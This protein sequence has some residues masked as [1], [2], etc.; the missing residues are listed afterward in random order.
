ML[1]RSQNESFLRNIEILGKIL[2]ISASFFAEYQVVVQRNSLTL[3]RAVSIALPGSPSNYFILN[4]WPINFIVP[5]CCFAS[6]V[7]HHGRSCLFTIGKLP[8]EGWCHNKD[9]LFYLIDQPWKPSFLVKRVKL[10][11]NRQISWNWPVVT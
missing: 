6:S 7:L 1:R 3:S 9:I 5:A 11:L 10:N 2:K 8:F 4:K